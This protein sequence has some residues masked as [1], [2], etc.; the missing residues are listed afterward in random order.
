MSDCFFR[1]RTPIEIEVVMDC[2][3]I[4]A[5]ATSI[6]NK[7]A[8]AR[9]DGQNTQYVNNMQPETDFCQDDNLVKLYF[10]E[11]IANIMRRIEPYVKEC[12]DGYMG[13]KIFSLI[14]PENWKASQ[15]PVLESKMK[16]YLVSYIVAQW[17]EKM[18]M[19]DTTYTTAKAAQ[20]LR[21]IKGVCELRKGKV[22]RVYDG[23]Y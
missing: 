4:A 10:D 7:M 18:S 5:T 16:N 13:N 6:L 9:F 3:D 12:K 17:L 11:G 22:H 2:D 19:S 1:T 20:L 21:D 23:T 15:Q 8:E 14:F